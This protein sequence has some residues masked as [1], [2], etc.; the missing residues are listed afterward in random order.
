MAL[1][2]RRSEAARRFLSDAVLR[3]SRDSS[4]IDEPRSNSDEPRPAGTGL[5]DADV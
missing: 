1:I 2:G 4:A 5:K 3:F